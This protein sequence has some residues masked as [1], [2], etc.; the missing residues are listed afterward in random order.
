MVNKH[1]KHMGNTHKRLTKK[2]GGVGRETGEDAAQQ[3]REEE[4]EA[5]ELGLE[6]NRQSML[7]LQNRCNTIPVAFPNK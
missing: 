1:T 2:Q 7:R 5:I 4:E 3:S 6:I